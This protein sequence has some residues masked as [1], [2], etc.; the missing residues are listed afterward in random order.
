M[1][2]WIVDNL[3]VV[4]LALC[5]IT[6]CC[7]WAWWTTRNAKLLI[8]VGVPIILMVLAWVLSLYIITD[9][10]QLVLDVQN[11]RDLVN[12]SQLDDALLHFD[13]EVKIDTMQGEMTLKKT[14]LRQLAKGN[15][16]LYG[17][18]K[19]DIWGIQ[20]EEAS[21]PNATLTFYLKPQDSEERGRCRMG[22]VYKDGKWRVTTFT[23]ESLVGGQ[24]S[25]LLLPF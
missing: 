19:I 17:V 3:G 8:G 7:S 24:K 13:D 1:L 16:R 21:R 14:D 6:L 18:K 5:I 20:V 15:M 4:F 12:A 23:V 2:W 11:M 22:F 25:P 9:R 10:T